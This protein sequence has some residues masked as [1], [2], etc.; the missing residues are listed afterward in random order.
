VRNE[1]PDGFGVYAQSAAVAGADVIKRFWLLL[2]CAAACGAGFALAA[3]ASKETVYRG[4][5]EV[6]LNPRVLFY[7]FVGLRDEIAYGREDPAALARDPKVARSA[8]TAV[9]L[10][11]SPGS[12]LSASSVQPLPG[13]SST[14]EFSV[15]G[16]DPVLASKLATAY[17]A[18]FAH[19]RRLRDIAAARRMLPRVDGTLRVY[20]A[21]KRFPKAGLQFLEQQRALLARMPRLPT[22]TLHPAHGSTKV[23]PRP[24]RGALLASILSALFTLGVAL[25][26]WR[27]GHPRR[28]LF[29]LVVATSLAGAVAF[30]VSAVWTGGS[31]SRAVGLT[32][33]GL[34]PLFA[35]LAKVALPLLA[36]VAVFA[37]VLEGY[38]LH[39]PVA[40]LSPGVVALLVFLLWIW[41]HT[42]TPLSN[43]VT[44]ILFASVAVLVAA[45]ALQFVNVPAGVTLRSLVSAGGFALFWLVGLYIARQ[46]WGMTAAG[47]GA[48]TALLV[49]GLAAIG[50]AAHFLS[51][52]SVI[53]GGR[54]FFGVRIPFSRTYGLSVGGLP[55]LFLPLSIPWLTLKV[56][57]GA[58]PE[59]RVAAAGAIIACLLF[60]LLF[61]QSRSMLLEIAVG[62][63]VV[64]LICVG[65]ARWKILGTG[66]AVG[67]AAVAVPSLLF[68]TDRLST[69]DRWTS[70][71]LAL[72]FFA[73]HPRAIIL[74]T[75]SAALARDINVRLVPPQAAGAPIHDT[76]IQFLAVG[77]VLA[78]LSAA[79]VLLVPIAA[80]LV[81][82][83]RRPTR[84]IG[85]AEA[86][87]PAVGAMVAIEMVSYA[88]VG[89]AG[90][91]WLALGMMA[92]YSGRL[93]AE[94]AAE[95]R[96]RQSRSP[97]VAVHAFGLRR[98]GVR[99]PRQ[100]D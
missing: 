97:A 89:N 4:R 22:A 70:Y 64:S 15:E 57:R 29:P 48:T 47:I 62:V 78:A 98:I 68:A 10:H 100:T 94:R 85:A 26:A 31:T 50:V 33:L 42:P 32:A 46:R 83:L 5:A 80:W 65:S 59:R 58:K 1:K 40:T 12:L 8:L 30:G 99:S 75:D 55:S 56:L 34:V 95:E 74:G 39:T 19:R 20:R 28:S 7:A 67:L 43:R 86:W 82:M 61:F 93:Y 27:P 6:V 84:P 60:V 45:H 72:T 24:I 66:A 41:R 44:Q 11:E 14:I 36:A 3:S 38:E 52:A 96:Q 79:A 13:D 37:Q 25:L 53:S 90:N 71:R 35:A 88:F 16:Q 23:Y 81:A 51:Q 63:T 92:G 2:V 76:F 17:A 73:H 69:G 9:G 91:G 87:I 49:L 21:R 54:S 18:A 77:G